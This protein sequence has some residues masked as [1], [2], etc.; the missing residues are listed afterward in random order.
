MY[1]QLFAG[2]LSKSKRNGGAFSFKPDSWLATDAIRGELAESWEWKTDPLRVEVKLRKGVMFPEKPGVMA[3][4]ELTSQDVVYSYN[5]M[6]TS[7]K[8]YPDF[9][10]HVDKVEGPDK[11]TVVIHFKSFHEDWGFRLGWGV[12]SSI[13]PK[14]VVDAGIYELDERRDL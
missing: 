2:D 12:Y 1:E 11:H 8:R 10:D 7:P 9:V 13:Y 3:A 14:E 6:L 5:R 4:R